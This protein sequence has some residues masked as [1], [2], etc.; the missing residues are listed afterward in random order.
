MAIILASQLNICYATIPMSEMALGGIYSGAD[1]QYV[2]KIYGKPD[3]IKVDQN[4]KDYFDGK[5]K[6]YLYGTDFH[7]LFVDNKVFNVKT[8]GKNGISTPSGITVGMQ[9]SQIYSTYGTP[10]NKSPNTCYYKLEG[11]FENFGIRFD[12]EKGKI[13][14]IMCGEFI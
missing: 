12:F 6:T 11:G 9:E 3:K 2:L 8:T 5:S 7:I 1:E 14:S 4:K 13:T 10:D